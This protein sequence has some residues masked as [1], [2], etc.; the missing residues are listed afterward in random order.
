MKNNYKGI[1]MS[2][3][4]L[5]LNSNPRKEGSTTVSKYKEEIYLISIYK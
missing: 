3:K 5:I 1:I 2:I 4:H